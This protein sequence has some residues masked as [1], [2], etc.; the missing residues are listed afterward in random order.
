MFESF[1]SPGDWQIM[2]GKFGD[3]TEQ[4]QNEFSL[5]FGNYHKWMDDIQMFQNFCA[6]TYQ[7]SVLRQVY[8]SVV[9]VSKGCQCTNE[10]HSSLSVEE[11][12]DPIF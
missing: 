8:S 5:K 11:N 9:G 4:L 1:T 2:K 10:L 6:L 3:I 12:P 7:F